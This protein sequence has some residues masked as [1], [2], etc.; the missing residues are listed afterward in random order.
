M[1][2]SLASGG[3]ETTVLLIAIIYAS[4]PVLATV[5]Q[6]MMLIMSRPP[7]RLYVDTRLRASEVIILESNHA[8]YL[9]HVLRLKAGADV[10]LFN[11]QDGEWRTEIIDVGR[12]ACT[13]RP[14][15]QSRP[16]DE[17]PKLMLAFAPLKKLPM[18]FLVEKA[19][20][21]GVGILQPVITERTE[22]SRLKSERL[23]A[24]AREAAEQCE[25]LTVPEVMPVLRL[26]DFVAAWPASQP[27][28]MGD[29]T[30]GGVA[31]ADALKDHAI[32]SPTATP[33]GILI[34]PEGG[35]TPRE[36]ETLDALAFVKRIDLGPRILRAETAALASLTCWQALLGDWHRLNH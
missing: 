25:R 17:S 30:G 23:A 28:W 9:G 5:A 35:F 11:G 13:L 14:T 1:G 7:P 33:H 4:W 8:H 34:G 26:A 2:M 20:E 19:T 16:Q 31:F 3:A 12:K 32:P 21:L 29:E 15:S 10:L 18:D 27:L 24:Q 22:T 36:L 6:R